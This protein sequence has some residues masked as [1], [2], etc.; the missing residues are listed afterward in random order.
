[1]SHGLVIGGLAALS[2]VAVLPA[3]SFRAGV[4]VVR[5]PVVVSSADGTA[6]EG[7]RAEDFQ[8]WDAGRP[9]EIVAFAVGG[10]GDDLPLH[11]GLMLDKSQSMEA[12]LST[13]AG[14]VIRFVELVDEAE[15]VTF[16]EFDTKVS[17]GRF[18]PS[19]YLRLFERI[20]R[21]AVGTKTAFYDAIAHYL[22]GVVG[23][24]GQHIL[25]AYTDGGDS[26]S[27]LNAGDI[28]QRLRLGDVVLYVI[29]YLEHQSVAA[30]SQQQMMLTALSRETGGDAFFPTSPKQLASFY[31]RIR[32][33]IAGRYVL[34]YVPSG[35]REPGQ[36]RR[37]EVRLRRNEV[38]GTRI[39][40]RS[41]YI[42]PA[43][44]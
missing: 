24:T 34:G 16:I 14:A 36:F 4:S 9:Q 40:A 38:K 8:I 19:N 33:E 29:G 7:L 42:A 11:L 44:P 30:R 28:R 20:R 43:A 15:D 13:A 32:A 18:T 2:V 26:A 3:Q 23:R 21:A 31:E 39:R 41:G 6:V 35:P 5:V 10:S 1:V 22:D 27:R 25:V 12:D 17:V 37:L